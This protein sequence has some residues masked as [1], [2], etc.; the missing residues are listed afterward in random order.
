MKILWVKSDFL[1]PTTK[2][3]H[4]RTLEML[5]RLHRRHEIH[6]VA[7]D[8]EEQPGGVERSS[9]YCTQAYPVAHRAAGRGTARFWL[10]AAGS[11]F[12]E[13]PLA[14]SRYRSTA[15]QRVIAD[16]TRRRKFDALVCDFLFAAPNLPDL[17]AAVLFQHNVEAQIWKRR[18]EHVART[19]ERLLL[20]NQYRRMRRYEGQVCRA[21]KR[22]AA[23]SEVDAETMRSEYGVADVQAVPTGVDVEYF[24]PPRELVAGSHLV[25]IGSMDWMPNVD[26][27]QWFVREALPRIRRSRPDCGL[28]IAG[29]R[30][31]PAISKLAEQ[32]RSIRV[33]GTVADIRPYLWESAVSI[34]PLR[35]GGGTRLKIFE[36]MAAGIPVVSTTIGAEGLEVRSGEN[37]RIADAPED[38]AEHCI[39]LLADAVSR[40]AIADRAWEMVS[41]CYS[42]EV[43][44]QKFEQLLT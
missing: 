4:I 3:G 35:I 33:T 19:P 30:P 41:A 23:V 31:H 8:L 1:H 38:F 2:G 24:K 26:G 29:R 39:Q 18:M 32:D 40:R 6:Y 36:A 10:Q 44:S 15:M 27:I 20:T 11:I 7:L 21:V 16:L 22:V 9:E 28:T 14:V 13:L 37:I 12:S 42:W 43:V 17:A 25:F 34:V 5:K